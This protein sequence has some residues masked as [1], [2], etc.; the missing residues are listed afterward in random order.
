VI[1]IVG[2]RRKMDN[3][4][5]VH[6]LRV[7]AVYAVMSKDPDTM[8]GAVIVGPDKEQR[9]AGFNGFPRGIADTE[10]RLAVKDKSNLDVKRGLMVHAET[11][12][13]Y[14]A[15]R[16]GIPIKGCTLYLICLDRGRVID[17]KDLMWGGPPC[18][19]C[20]LALIQAGITEVV[21]I[22]HKAV[23][24]W[25]ENVSVSRSLLKEAWVEYR[26]IPR[27]LMDGT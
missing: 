10:E 22:P 23:S 7:C 6:W 25:S 27:E 14:N 4:W 16:V 15:A 3:R 2:R 24:R 12:A 13:I 26:E 21:S 1:V 5:D 17:P 9:S 8:V 18:V 20:T 19:G 11:N